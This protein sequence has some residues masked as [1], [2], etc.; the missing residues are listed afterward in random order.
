MPLLI[1]ELKDWTGNGRERGNDMQ[2]HRVGIKP[3]A[4]TAK[5]YP[6]YRGHP[7]YQ[8]SQSLF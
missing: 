1:G 2:G 7:L 3:V 6:L 5:A 4:T 8:L